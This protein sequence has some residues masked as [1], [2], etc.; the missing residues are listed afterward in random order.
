MFDLADHEKNMEEIIRK[1]R[2]RARLFRG[3]V[4][5]REYYKSLQESQAKENEQSPPSNPPSKAEGE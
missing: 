2:E 1:F 3:F 4:V 5:G